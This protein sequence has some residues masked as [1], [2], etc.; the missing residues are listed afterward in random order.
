MKFYIDPGT[1]SMLFTILIGILG[2]LRYVF[3]SWFVKLRFFFS[4]GRKTETNSD[5]IP[6]VIFSDGKQYWTYLE[7][8]CREL[9]KKGFDVVYMTAD[10]NDPVLQNPY[11]HI[12]GRFI[13][14]GNKAFAKLNFLKATV[15]FSTTP[16]LDV[17]QWKR[18]R[19]VKCYVHIMHAAKDLTLY[20]M[21]GTDYYDVLL[22][23][24]DYQVEQARSLEKLWNIPERECA[25][26][27]VPYLDE[28]LKRYKENPYI[29]KNDNKVVLLAP[30]WGESG[31][32]NRFGEKIIDEL[33]ATG[34][35]IIV[36]PHPQSFVS[37]K[38]MLQKLMNQYSGM[39]RLEWNR[40][41]DNFEVLK[42]ADILIS[43]FSGVMFDFALVYDKPIIYTD[44]G[45]DKGP[46]DAWWLDEPL[47]IFEVLPTI[48]KELNTGNMHDLKNMIDE[49]LSNEKYA[50]GREQARKD[51]WA[52]QGES[53]ERTAEY[54]I[55]KYI[56]L[57]NNKEE[58][59]N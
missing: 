47:W 24:G 21:F 25:I 57:N 36:R 50:E 11:E 6:L 37:E 8:I 51:T 13:G 28:M 4:G 27:G 29:E 46:Y 49:C 42:K 43:D 35:H 38:D 1:G 32:L 52:H 19:E 23:A 15:V 44:T 5:E 20:R 22:L 59:N 39:E 53:A 54:L 26:V 34:Y 41:N 7:P 40:D 10:P 9:D 30:S 33:L 31:I 18:S 14:E 17:Y 3:K 55:Q 45:F 58:S 16:G 56:E 12:K 48:G 2:A